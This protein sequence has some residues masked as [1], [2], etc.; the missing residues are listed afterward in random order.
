M[1]VSTIKEYLRDYVESITE[2]SIRGAYICPLCGSGTGKDKSGAFNID[3]KDPTRWKCFKCEESGDIFDLIGRYENIPEYSDQVTRAREFLGDIP[4][5]VER[6]RSQEVKEELGKDYSAYY[7][8]C[9]QR[10]S[11]ETA[12]A[13]LSRRGI[14]KETAQRF[15]IGYDP[16]YTGESG[17]LNWQVIIIPTSSG[18]FVARNMDPEGDR[19]RKAGASQIFNLSALK[20]AKKPVFVVEGEID[21]LSIIEAGGEAVGLGSTSNKVKLLSYL[22]ENVPSQS[23]IL[24]LDNDDAGKRT[25]EELKNELQRLKIDFYEAEI[26][27]SYKDANE[28]LTSDREAFIHAVMETEKIEET[29]AQ[30]EKVNYLRNS[31][32]NYIDNFMSDII[33]DS[34]NRVISTGFPKLDKLLDGGLYPGL[35]IIGAASSLGKTT[36]A[37]QMADQIAQQGRDVLIISLEMARAE[38]MA[39]SI[40]RLTFLEAYNSGGWIQNAKTTRGI[41][42]GSRY[43]NYSEAELDLIDKAISAYK[44]YAN[45]IFIHEGMGDLGAEQIR[46]LVEQHKKITGKAPVLLVDYL[47]IMAPADIRATD[48]QNADRN[49]VELKRISRDYEIPVISISAVNRASYS[50][51]I[52]ME[53]LKESG[54][55]EYGSDVVIGMNLRGVGTDGFNLSEAKAKKPREIDVEIL[56]Q[57]NGG[58]GIVDFDYNTLFNYYDDQTKKREPEREEDIFAAL[59]S[60]I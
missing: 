6:K 47:Q 19:Y 35:Y 38:L 51:R 54:G 33:E 34:N 20:T 58:L 37:L 39:K 42:T 45:H 2:K 25:Q 4:V 29:K 11:D 17:K 16:H 49:T 21:A 59:R 30:E 40:S 24:A 9:A 1:E 13:Y 23:L 8:E 57:R 26:Y 56:K 14:S 27:G 41:M 18:S 55:I 48:K 52:T 44:K 3:P 46:E 22:R 10:I 32:A 5:R 43:A 60:K 12:T 28:A 7:K 31:A 50:S 15:N 53:S 36:F